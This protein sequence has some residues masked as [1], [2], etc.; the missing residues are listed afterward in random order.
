MIAGH[1]VTALI[2]KQKVPK[3]SLL[4]FLIAS[5]LQDL[6]WFFFHYLGLE[7]TLPNDIFSATLIW[8]SA[9]ML[10]SHDMLPLIFWLL[11][12]FLIGKMYFKSTLI[13]LTGSALVLG[14]TVLDFFSGFPHH[15]FWAESHTVGLGLYTSNI[16]L[17]IFIEALF[18]TGALYYFFKEEKKEW[19]TRST[20]NK[21]SIIGLFVYG[22]CFMLLIAT[23]S[24]REWFWIPDF[25]I[26]FSTIIPAM[27]FMYLGM[28][29]YLNYFVAQWRK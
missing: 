1:Y 7:T 12:I 16:Y 22:I 8:L 17:A 3:G 10:Y 19:V 23:T 6:L 9:D 21:A 25:E 24:F 26:H 5:Q 18:V 11:I 20:I 2:A 28:I 14:H 15:I 4:F 27:I 29:V 13:A